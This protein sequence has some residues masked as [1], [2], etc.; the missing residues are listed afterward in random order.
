[1]GFRKIAATMGL[2]LAVFGLSGCIALGGVD[3]ATGT[4]DRS[5]GTARN[6]SILLNIIRASRGEPLYFY[7][8][9]RVSGSGLE[10][11]KFSLPALTLGPNRTASQRNFTFGSN[12]LDVLESQQSGSFDVALLESKN[13]YQGM[14]APLDLVE[15]DLLLKQ[16]FPRELVYRLVVKDITVY[17]GT[18]FQRF[19]NDPTSPSYAGFQAYFNTAMSDGITTETYA[20][21]KPDDSPDAGNP[22]KSKKPTGTMPA[23]RLCW[24][25][26]LA[27]DKDGKI[28]DDLAKSGNECGVSHQGDQIQIGQTPPGLMETYAACK[29]KDDALKAS[30]AANA[31]NAADATTTTAHSAAK[32]RVCVRAFGGVIAVQLNTRSLFGIFQYLGQQLAEQAD[33]TAPKH[34][35]V[36]LKGLGAPVEATAAPGPL[37]AIEMGGRRCFAM[38]SLDKRYCIPLD[39]SDN[40]KKTFSMINA[41][42]ALKTSPGDLPVTQSV[43]IEQ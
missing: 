43:R 13:F 34:P 28:V 26:A 41:L 7:S 11:F 36:L 40:L 29:V 24:D 14:L 9:S 18:K 35:V 19:L 8:I 4:I 3:R 25:R 1:M 32:D 23:A 15:V 37:L 12:G 22:T 20:V 16:G 39:A 27:Q 42:Q 30:V 10:D 31:A 17:N 38:V 6:N 2:L 5:V 21:A 33:T